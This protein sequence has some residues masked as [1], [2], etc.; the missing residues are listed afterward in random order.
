MERQAVKLRWVLRDGEKVLQQWT[1]QG[2]EITRLGYG[3]HPHKDLEPYHEWVD[4]PVA[5]EEDDNE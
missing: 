5:G 4:I 2:K 3:D 1:R